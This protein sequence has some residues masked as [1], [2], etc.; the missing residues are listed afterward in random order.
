MSNQFSKPGNR[1]FL[2]GNWDIEI[3]NTGVASETGTVL[4][5]VI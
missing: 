5:S 3:P 4:I 1:V 2:K